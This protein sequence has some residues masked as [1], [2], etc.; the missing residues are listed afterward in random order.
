[1]HR[2]R[3]T[4]R[5]KLTVNADKYIFCHERNGLSIKPDYP[6]KICVLLVQCME[7]FLTEIYSNTTAEF[8]NYF[9]CVKLWF[10]LEVRPDKS[11]A[12]PN[13]RS[14]LLLS[15]ELNFLKCFEPTNETIPDWKGNSRSYNCI[16]SST[17]SIWRNFRNFHS[18]KI[19]T[20]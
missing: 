8:W 10:I 6:M 7:K 14:L 13:S 15:F 3:S 9:S 18:A 20:V 12:R 1:M 2:K 17:E 19:L 4:K 16:W 11:K 5:E